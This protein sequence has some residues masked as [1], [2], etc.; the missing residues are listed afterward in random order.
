MP[1]VSDL[2]VIE[3]VENLSKCRKKMMSLEKD[4]LGIIFFK[5]H[6]TQNIDGYFLCVKYLIDLFRDCEFKNSVSGYYF[7]DIG[8]SHSRAQMETF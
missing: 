3:K 5:S 4:L 8:I 7:N 1:N 2:A 6:S